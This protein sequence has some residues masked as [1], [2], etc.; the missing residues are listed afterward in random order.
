[1]LTSPRGY[2]LIDP[3]S[4]SQAHAA[5]L[6]R[7][8]G[9]RGRLEVARATT[10]AFPWMLTQ[11]EFVG[12]DAQLEMLNYLDLKNSAVSNVMGRLYFGR[13]LGRI[14]EHLR[15]G[16]PLPG[17]RLSEIARTAAERIGASRLWR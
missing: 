6:A 17:C 8:D 14:E 7:V 3:L 16:P 15:S 2:A 13:L 1:M 12:G 4:D 11:R 5:P 10:P 9:W